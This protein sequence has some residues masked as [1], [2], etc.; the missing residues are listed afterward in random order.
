METVSTINVFATMDG[1]GGTVTKV[2]IFKFIVYIVG[3]N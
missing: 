3:E 2:Q 1:K